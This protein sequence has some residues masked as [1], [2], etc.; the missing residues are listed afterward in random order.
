MKIFTHFVLLSN[1]LKKFIQFLKEHI[2]NLS[3]WIK[4]K[5]ITKNEIDQFNFNFQSILQEHPEFQS[6]KKFLVKL[7]RFPYDEGNSL[8]SG[9]FGVVYEGQAICNIYAKWT[10]PISSSFVPW[11]LPICLIFPSWMKICPRTKDSLLN[12]SKE[13]ILNSKIFLFLFFCVC[14]NSVTYLRIYL[15]LYKR[16]NQWNQQKSDERILYWKSAIVVLILPAIAN[17]KEEA[18]FTFLIS[19]AKIALDFY[20]EIEVNE[21]YPDDDST[22]ADQVETTT[23]DQ[24]NLETHFDYN[25]FI[26]FML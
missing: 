10:S 9:G 12:F 26:K 4:I 13:Y 6:L 18:I 5:W 22:T 24:N 3:W 14:S 11:I 19:L 8:G 23:G 20:R 15:I 16:K 25:V 21:K 17:L 7:D 2:K 1:S